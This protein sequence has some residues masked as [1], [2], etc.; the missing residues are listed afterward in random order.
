M[1]EDFNNAENFKT[2]CMAC[3]KLKLIKAIVVGSNVQPSCIVPLDFP[4]EDRDR[5]GNIS[6]LSQVN[7]SR[8]KILGIFP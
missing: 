2:K 6:F 5:H 1:R 8:I 3:M 7:C 4:A